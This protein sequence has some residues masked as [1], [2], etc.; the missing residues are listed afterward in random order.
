MIVSVTIQRAS[1]VAKHV[2]VA[3]PA[4]SGGG[5]GGRA[6][7]RPKCGNGNGVQK[8]LRPRP[9]PRPCLRLPPTAH[10]RCS[11]AAVLPPVCR[12][13]VMDGPAGTQCESVRSLSEVSCE[14]AAICGGDPGGIGVSC[15]AAVNGRPAPEDFGILSIP[16]APPP[17][18]SA[19]DCLAVQSEPLVPTE[20][21]LDFWSWQAFHLACNFVWR[22]YPHNF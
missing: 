6:A 13:T 7:G 3:R 10:R 21:K 18:D 11:W 17:P 14:K 2:P 1:A 20:E 8:V 4:A 22:V 19:D 15:C 12:A 5:G 9:R 16:P